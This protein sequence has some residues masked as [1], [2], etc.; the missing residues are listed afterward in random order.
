MPFEV[1]ELRENSAAVS[2]KT[3]ANKPSNCS[4]KEDADF[5]PEKNA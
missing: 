5:Q 4:E 2:K 3:P 1:V